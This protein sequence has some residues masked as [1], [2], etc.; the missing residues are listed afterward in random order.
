MAYV[1]QLIVAFKEIPPLDRILQLV[2]YHRAAGGDLRLDRRRQIELHA[3]Q[4]V[5]ILK[6][7]LFQQ[8]KQLRVRRMAAR[9]DAAQFAAF[10]AELLRAREAPISTSL[11][12][13][14]SNSMR[15][16]IGRAG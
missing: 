9:V 2:V 10:P 6:S 3:N 8:R 15:T 12:C 4:S 5:R 16:C 14:P 13:A 1:E 7:E 11:I